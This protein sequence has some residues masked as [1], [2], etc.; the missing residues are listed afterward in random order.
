MVVT[1]QPGTRPIYVD[2]DIL[3]KPAATAW[4]SKNQPTVARV[5][6]FEEVKACLSATRA[7]RTAARAPR[8]GR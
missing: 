7:R 6:T 3:E 2:L 4:F 5:S 8:R 1:R